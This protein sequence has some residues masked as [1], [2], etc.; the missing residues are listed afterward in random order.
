MNCFSLRG[1][2][3]ICKHNMVNS[4]WIV[5]IQRFSSLFVLFTTPV[6]IHPFTL[7]FTH[8]RQGDL[9]PNSQPAHQGLI[10]I[11]T[12]IAQP[13]GA[14]WAS[15]GL[16]GMQTGRVGYQTNNPPI[17]KLIGRQPILP[18]E[19]QSPQYLLTNLLSQREH[20]LFQISLTLK[21]TRF[22]H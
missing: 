20:K 11:H 16:L 12:P 7:T 13:L 17:G 6:I 18:S 21:L 2:A 9:Y 8:S 10:N 1:S 19:L 3:F 4:K 22:N 15:L 14:V 5:F